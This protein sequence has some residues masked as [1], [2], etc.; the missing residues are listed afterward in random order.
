MRTLEYTIKDEH[1]IHARPAGALVKLATGFSSDI[2]IS[3]GE[4]SGDLKRIFS[5]MSL[6]AKKG[7]TIK[8]DA[9]GS[10]EEQAIEKIEGFLKENL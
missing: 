7:E 8:I 4:K 9:D 2:K 5:V 6:G 3:K 1:G 10:D